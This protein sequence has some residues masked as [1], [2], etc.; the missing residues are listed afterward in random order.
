MNA[1]AAIQAQLVDVRNVSSH[2]CVRLEIHV[3]AEQAGHVMAA[4]GWPTMAEPVPVALARLNPEATAKPDTAKERTPF[5]ELPLSQ[6]A[7][8]RCAEPDFFRFMSAKFR[9]DAIIPFDPKKDA[10]T[11]PVVPMLRHHLGIGSRR[12]LDLIEEKGNA[13]LTLEAEYYAWQ[14]GRR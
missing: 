6:Q 3:P 8:L 12:D 4:F 1:P 9:P 7:A 13:W 14:R 11:A 2:K 5:T 10:N